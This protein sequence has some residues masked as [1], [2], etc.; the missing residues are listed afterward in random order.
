[1]RL[2]TQQCSIINN[3]VIMYIIFIVIVNLLYY[4]DF[5]FF[6]IYKFPLDSLI[7]YI[8]CV[9]TGFIEKSQGKIPL[10]LTGMSFP[11]P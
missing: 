7:F 11:H 8:Q 6:L 3:T 1:M 4:C 2:N 9:F 10:F 5:N